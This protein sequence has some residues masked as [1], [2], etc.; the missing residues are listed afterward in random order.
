MS[1]KEVK[2]K[3]QQLA[4]EQLKERWKEK[5]MHGQYPQRLQDGDVDEEER[6]RQ[7]KSAGLKSE[8]EGLIV[9]AQD[10][11]L[12]TKHMQSKIIKKGTDPNC[13]IQKH[14]DH[15]TSG[16]RELAKTKH[17]HRHNKVAAYGLQNSCRNFDIKVSGKWYEHQPESVIE[18]KK[19]NYLMGPTSIHRL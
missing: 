19:S 6:N 1:A 10:Q 4:Q 12:K 9:V 8:T 7:L 2:K 13:R 5:K 3:A 11:A 17:I 14:I 15:I 18:R 16:C